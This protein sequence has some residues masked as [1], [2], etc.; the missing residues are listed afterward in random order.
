MHSPVI[1]I[2]SVFKKVLS[3]KFTELLTRILIEMEWNLTSLFTVVSEDMKNKFTLSVFAHLAKCLSKWAII[4]MY[5]I[6]INNLLKQLGQFELNLVW[7]FH[8]VFCIDMMWEFWSFEKNMATVTINRRQGSDRI[9][10]HI[11]PKLL[12]LAKIWQ[13]KEFSTVRSINGPT[14]L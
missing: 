10:S 8:R 12:D 2:D 9:F 5:V 7:M 13:V 3:M 6:I 4:I 11:F 1:Y 14:S